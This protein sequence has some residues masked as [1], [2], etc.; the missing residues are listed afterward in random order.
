MAEPL[1]TLDRRWRSACKIL[2][3]QEVGPLSDFLPYLEGLIEP[4]LHRKSSVSGKDVA[5]AVREY[6]EGSKWIS[7]DEVDFNKKFEKLNINEIKDI[8]ALLEAVS[9]RV[10]Y[11]GNVILGNS[12]RVER[13]SNISDSF[14][15]R[16][17]AIMGDSKYVA[18]C[19]V[20]RL[21]EDCFGTYGPGESSYCIRCTQTYRDKRCFELWTS[22]N[23]SDCY[24]VYNLQACSDCIFCFNTKNK[25]K[26]IGNLELAPDKYSSIKEKLLAEM[27]EGLRKNK[28][29]PSLMDI[30][31]KSRKEKPPAITEEEDD[32]EPENKNVIEAEFAKTAGLL[33]GARLAGLDNYKQWLERHTHSVEERQ[34]AVSGK[35]IYM[36]PRMTAIPEI[37]RD[38][39]V[40]AQESRKLGEIIQ[41]SA[42]EVE[43]LSITN[44]HER[45]GKLAYLT[46]DFSEGANTN[47]IECATSIDS[48]CSYRTSGLVYSKHCGYMF[49][50]R[51]TEHSYGCEAMFDSSFCI[52]CYYSQ[53]LTRC[54][55][56]DSCRSCSDCY[57]C[58]NCENVQDSMF[59][60]NV[61]NMK[62]AIGNVE[63]GREEYLRIKKLVL[64]EIAG[65]LM[66]EHDFSLDIYNIGKAR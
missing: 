45:I 6:A 42:A 37:P 53:K 7:F 14:F 44:A 16:D 34:S 41:L 65:R 20:G 19:I 35:T 26:C 64:A 23:C 29:L 21:D 36:T 56:C 47:L 2:F 51:S 22:Q 49:W 31:R 60:F 58:H 30:V 11:T 25:R 63:V 4:N 33:L 40:T 18:S 1:D 13:S 9:E 43:T 48:T 52:N 17:S 38:R 8:D 55:E 57:Y 39:M 46:V 24:Y 5:Y 54:Y 3:K 59:C 32:K 61:K 12:G 50:P 62:Y 28:Q 10:Y 66:K 27:A 15:M